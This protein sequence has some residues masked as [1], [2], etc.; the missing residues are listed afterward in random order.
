MAIVERD[1]WN[2]L[3]VAKINGWTIGV[4]GSQHVLGWLI[5]FP[6]EKIE[7]SLA[8]LSDEEILAFKKVA[9]I[10]EDLLT[11]LFHP[12]WFNYVQTG[13]V[14]KDL[15]IHLQPRYSSPREFEGHSFNDIGWG[16][17]VRNLRY[18]YLPRK[19]IV[20]KIVDDLKTALK[21]MGLKDL[22]V[23]ILNED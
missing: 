10:G 2:R 21:E 3:H 4:S 12:D 1:E 5:I 15:H 7:G 17:T 13:N 14:V 23:E 8:D 19:D 6:P 16:K 20:F 22:K 18:E 9:R 11:K